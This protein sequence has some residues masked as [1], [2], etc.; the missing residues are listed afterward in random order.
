ME[1]EILAMLRANK[2]DLVKLD[3]Q[4]HE[5]LNRID[6][7]ILELTKDPLLEEAILTL[8]RRIIS[9]QE[10]KVFSMSKLAKAYKG[11][12]EYTD[13]ILAEMGYMVNETPESEVKVKT[14]QLQ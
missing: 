1:Q 10:Q 4:V 9:L 14:P 2:A 7:E 6:N 8:I 3:A 13:N 5:S 12:L 11:Q